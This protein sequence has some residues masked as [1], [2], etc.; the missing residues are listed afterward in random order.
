M[1]TLGFVGLVVS[2]AATQLCGGYRKIAIA[3]MQMNGC[4]CVLVKLYL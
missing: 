2:I 1:N 4:V 3:S